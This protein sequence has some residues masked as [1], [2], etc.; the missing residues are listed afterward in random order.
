[1]VFRSNLREFGRIYRYSCDM[2]RRRRA[3]STVNQPRLRI[4]RD[5]TRG[6]SQRSSLPP[7]VLPMSEHFDDYSTVN[8][9]EKIDIADKEKP[10]VLKRARRKP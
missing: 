7:L 1:M 9:G 10:C 4:R 2:A 3:R 6:R 8:R 5:C